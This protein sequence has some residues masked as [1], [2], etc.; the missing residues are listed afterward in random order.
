MADQGS[1]Q[2]D[3]ETAQPAHLPKL[4]WVSIVL[5]GLL[6]AVGAVIWM[7]HRPSRPETL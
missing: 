1:I 7:K 6:A 3:R 5:V 2:T 4:G